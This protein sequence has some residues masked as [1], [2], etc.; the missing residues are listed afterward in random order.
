MRKF[1]TP[2]L[3][4]PSS[5]PPNSPASTDS[6]PNSSE[7]SEPP[8]KKRKTGKPAKSEKNN[9]PRGKD[10][11]P[12]GKVGSLKY[13]K[14]LSHQQKMHIQTKETMKKSQATSPRNGPG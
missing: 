9:E 4:V 11:L 3:D 10:K 14:L 8:S 1:T 13:N 6:E 7:V 2:D 12:P 5:E